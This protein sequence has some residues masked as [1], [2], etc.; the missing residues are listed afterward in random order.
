[1]IMATRRPARRSRFSKDR[2]DT[3]CRRGL[4]D[5]SGVPV[6]QPQASLVLSSSRCPEVLDDDLLVVVGVGC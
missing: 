1:M 4:D 6:E 2:G 3:E 5:E